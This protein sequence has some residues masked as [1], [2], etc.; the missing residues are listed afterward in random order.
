MSW[1]RMFIRYYGRTGEKG[2]HEEIII[3]NE[4]SDSWLQNCYLMVMN[5]TRYVLDNLEKLPTFRVVSK[6]T[7]NKLLSKQEEYSNSKKGKVFK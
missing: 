3:S 2:V 5:R 7:Y 1:L 4:E 6:E